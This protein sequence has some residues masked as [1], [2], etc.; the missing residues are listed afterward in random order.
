MRKTYAEPSLRQRIIALAAAYAIGLASLIS[1]FSGASTAAAATQ[2]GEALCHSTIADQPPTSSDDGNGKIC[3]GSCC[4][5]CLML[6]AAVPP[7]PITVIAAPQSIGQR[8]APP[9]N[10]V[11]AHAAHTDSHRSRAPPLAA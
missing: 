5:G 1:S 11:F 3:V 7:P 10:S 9:E 4:V 8:L 6:I 2:P